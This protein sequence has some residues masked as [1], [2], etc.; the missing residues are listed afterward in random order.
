M[1]GKSPFPTFFVFVVALA[2]EPSGGRDLHPPAG[3]L[4]VVCSDDSAERLAADGS[5]IRLRGRLRHGRGTDPVL[6]RLSLPRRCCFDRHP[7]VV[8]ACPSLC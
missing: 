4:R 6:C 2:S 8:A 3:V 5:P 1:T 7:S